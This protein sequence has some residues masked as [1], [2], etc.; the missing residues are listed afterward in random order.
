MRRLALHPKCKILLCFIIR[1]TKPESA[2]KL[3]SQRPCPLR[4]LARPILAEHAGWPGG[5]TYLA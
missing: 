4:K 2:A 1:R 3:S 5:P